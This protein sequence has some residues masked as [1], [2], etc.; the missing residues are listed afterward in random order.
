ML[1]NL[2]VVAQTTCEEAQVNLKVYQL[3]GFPG[4]I[5][6]NDATHIMLEKVQY[7]FRQAR[8]GFKMTHTARTYNMHNRQVKVHPA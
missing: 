2:Y 1:Y 8:L 6:S 4:A 7:R 3:A 5:G